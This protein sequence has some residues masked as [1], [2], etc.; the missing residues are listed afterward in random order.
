MN[1]KNKHLSKFDYR[2]I[3]F[4]ECRFVFTTS[5]GF[6]RDNSFCLKHFIQIS[7]RHQLI[8]KEC[9]NIEDEVDDR[10]WVL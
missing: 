4:C 6:S 9:R 7:F 2:A 10:G 5:A 3:S 1:V 8:L